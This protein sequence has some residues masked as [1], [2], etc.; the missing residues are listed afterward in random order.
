MIPKSGSALAALPEASQ[1]SLGSRAGKCFK[2]ERKIDGGGDGELGFWVLGLWGR[3]TFRVLGPCTLQGFRF[4]AKSF[5]I[6]LELLRSSEGRRPLG[7]L[8]GTT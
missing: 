7:T 5:G 2:L 1:L 4:R 3:F 8:W 6:R